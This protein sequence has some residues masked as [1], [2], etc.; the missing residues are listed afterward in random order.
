[1]DIS[2]IISKI[3]F[4]QTP[5][6]LSFDSNWKLHVINNKYI[7]I[8]FYKITKGKI[9]SSYNIFD[10]S[11]NL[12]HNTNTQRGRQFISNKYLLL[13]TNDNELIFNKYELI[14]GIYVHQKI[15][16]ADY[17]F[18][19]NSKSFAVQGITDSHIIVQIW[20]NIGESKTK[21]LILSIDNGSLI[22]TIT[23]PETENFFCHENYIMICH[24]S[25]SAVTVFTLNGSKIIS[26]NK[27]TIRPPKI[28]CTN[29]ATLCYP[30]VIYIDYTKRI[31]VYNLETK[32]G[33]VFPEIL[34]KK[35]IWKETHV[36]NNILILVFSMFVKKQEFNLFHFYDL[37]SRVLVKNL[38]ISGSEIKFAINNEFLFV[39][40][41]N[42][43]QI[44]LKSFPL[45]I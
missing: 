6:Y 16:Q 44:E 38:I 1:M 23:L 22:N 20:N 37:V 18:D 17:S 29:N 7:C 35:I 9:Y 39:T 4:S 5:K 13:Q 31:V 28:F 8:D 45:L 33:F 42:N 24:D 15:I 30:Y 27:K 34:P 2:Q 10:T 19:K 25:W 3:S 14:D 43:N 21:T 11:N 32:R 41:E 40:H 36:H 12:A 26:F